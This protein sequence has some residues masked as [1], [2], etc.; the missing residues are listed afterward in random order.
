MYIFGIAKT[1]LVSY[2]WNVHLSTCFLLKRFV[3]KLMLYK[4]KINQSHVSMWFYDFVLII[5]SLH[6]FSIHFYFLKSW[7]FSPMQ[8]QTPYDIGPFMNINALNACWTESFSKFW[9]HFLSIIYHQD[10]RNYIYILFILQTVI[11]M[12][13]IFILNSKIVFNS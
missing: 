11:H 7:F 12:C 3:F 8:W 4:S 5:S 1:T 9:M 6:S 10:G 2:I 13:I